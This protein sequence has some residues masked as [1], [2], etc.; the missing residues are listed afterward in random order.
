[1]HSDFDMEVTS[2]HRELERA[3][4]MARERLQAQLDQ[5]NSAWGR[6]HKESALR[7]LLRWFNHAP[8]PVPCPDPQ[9][10]QSSGT[11]SL[12]ISSVK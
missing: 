5:Q 9:T 10:R 1:M 12:S 3:Q 7:D 6:L 11:A 8:A 2:L 4:H